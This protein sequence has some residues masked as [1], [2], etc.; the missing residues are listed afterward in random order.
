MHSSIRKPV[1]ALVLG[2]LLALSCEKEAVQT[3][4]VRASIGLTSP[5]TK[6]SVDKD[7]SKVRWEEGDKISLWARNTDGLSLKAQEFSLFGSLD[8][9]AIFTTILPAAMTPGIYEYVACY[10]APESV[11]G[12]TVNFELP[13]VQDGDFSEYDILV[14]DVQTSGA[15][16]PTN[17]VE[18]YDGL[19]LALNHM[20]HIF[21]VFVPADFEK[22]AEGAT[23]VGVLFTRSLAGTLQMSLYEDRVLSIIKGAGNKITAPVRD[24]KARIFTVPFEGGAQDKLQCYI[25]SSNKIWYSPVISLEGRNFEGGHVTPLAWTPGSK[26][27]TRNFSIE[28]KGNELGEPVKT[29]QLTAPEGWTWDENGTN[30]L[31]IEAEGGEFVPDTK[32]DFAYSVTDSLYDL[33]TASVTAALLTDHFRVRKECDIENLEVFQWGFDIAAPQLLNE[34]FSSL[35]SFSNH[36]EATGGSKGD[37]GNGFSTTFLDGWSGG[38]VG[39]EAGKCIRIAGRRECGLGVDVH[40]PARVDSKPM[41]DVIAPVDLELSFN[42]GANETGTITFSTYKNLGQKFYVGYVF[43]KEVRASGNAEIN[44]AQQFSVAAGVKDGS[45]DATP[46]HLTLTFTIPEGDDCRFTWRNDPNGRSDRLGGNTT[47]WLYIDNISVKLK[48]AEE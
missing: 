39:G 2:S 20:C 8:N 22:D 14:T 19:K 7:L 5:Q 41:V 12:S 21:D 16:K 32:Y 38:R 29:L 37:A 28:Y 26:K 6:T 43:G 1:T 31:S 27:I 9:D 45:F 3:P 34:D 30:I 4:P 24:G 35:E 10:P 11:A 48:P 36:D 42:Y 15:L 17:K 23:K 18:N 46:N 33:G 44:G 40:Y 13:A 25:A 47:V